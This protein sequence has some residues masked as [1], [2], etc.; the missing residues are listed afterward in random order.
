[1]K[2]ESFYILFQGSKAGFLKKLNNASAVSLF[3]VLTLFFFGPCQI[4][5]TNALELPFTFLEL[6]R[7]LFTG[8][9]IAFLVTTAGLVFL[10][11]KIHEKATVLVFVIAVLFWVH[12]N[13]LVWNY[14]QL[15]GRPIDWNKYY[16]RNAIDAC[17]WVILIVASLAKSKNI[18][19]LIPQCAIAFIII[20]SISTIAIAARAHKPDSPNCFIDTSH[21]FTFSSKKN[22]IFVILDSLQSDIFQEIIDEDNHYAEAFDG[23]TYFKNS[24]GGFATTIP[25]IPLIFTGQY[26]DNSMPYPQFVKKAYLS[27]SI[28]RN[29]K[30]R[31]FQVDLFPNMDI[32]VCLNKLIASNFVIDKSAKKIDFEEAAY[33]Y[34]L[35]LFRYSPSFIKKLTY[36][37]QHWFLKKIA[38]K[39]L[40]K[41]QSAVVSST[42]DDSRVKTY[43][44]KSD[45]EFIKEF[46]SL[47]NIGT[48]KYV[49]KYFHMAGVHF[50]VT[51]NE[52]L[53]IVNLP[54]NR[55]GCRQKAKGELVLMREFLN[56][57]KKIG[58]YDNSMIFI[59]GDHGLGF[60][61]FYSP[62]GSSKVASVIQVDDK[63]RAMPLLIIKPFNSKAQISI[64]DAPVS[65][66]DIPKTV[67]SQLGLANN[68]PGKSIFEIKPLD[69]RERKYLMFPFND[70]FWNQ[71][72]GP[73]MR[74]YFVSG[75]SW[76]DASWRLSGRLYYPRTGR[77][78]FLEIKKYLKDMDAEFIEKN[79]NPREKVLIVLAKSKLVLY[80]TLNSME[81]V[82]IQYGRG[83][84]TKGDSSRIDKFL[85]GNKKRNIFLDVDN[86]NMAWR[87]LFEGCDVKDK[88]AKGMVM[89]TCGMCKNIARNPNGD[90]IVFFLRNDNMIMHFKFGQD[91]AIIDRDGNLIRVDLKDPIV[92]LNNINKFSFAPLLL[93]NVFS[94][95]IL[96]NPSGPQ[97]SY[98]AIISNHPGSNY[99]E[100]FVVQQD[101]DKQN[102]FSFGFGNGQQ[103]GKSVNFTL[104]ERQWNYIA[105]VVEAN[106]VKL[107]VNGKFINSTDIGIVMKNS[108]LALDMGNWIGNDRAFNGLIREISIC[109][110]S[111]D[112]DKIGQ[113]WEAIKRLAG[114]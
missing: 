75:F 58:I 88:S 13:V 80:G 51:F 61:G 18:Y 21:E 77:L 23:F 59:M 109:G 71:D 52:K 28:P 41:K 3:F 85:R 110:G 60:I 114:R 83:G 97:V 65:L 89:L 70:S 42:V 66:S 101:G 49:F 31:G 81:V 17:I 20:Q 29:L 26:Y 36:N 76:L 93:P 2:K 73:T 63:A 95:E 12:G 96:V 112:D 82:D 7:Y 111:L 27:N 44:Q 34:D 24:L 37:D 40:A 102:T 38:G 107:Y 53:E 54:Q 39:Y 105:I 86:R 78:S 94:L 55:Q 91:A 32:T 68:F 64:S 11:E 72:Y 100:G 69:K 113:R 108:D 35:V 47:A 33:L 98:A 79:V 8:F 43:K 4:Y 104:N 15:D 22:V 106:I 87:T 25:S 50:P 92:C 84:I 46:E 99:Y 48:D 56:T 57:L 74:E 16:Y 45:I 10:K 19:K 9:L 5:F 1:M 62:G 30:D 67:F 14:G 6:G 90:N 103:W